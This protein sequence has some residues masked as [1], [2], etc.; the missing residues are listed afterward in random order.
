[1]SNHYR[2]NSVSSQAGLS[3]EQLEDR[4]IPSVSPVPTVDLT[5]RESSGE[6]NGAIFRQADAQPTGTGVINS[7]VRLQALGNKSGAQHGYNTDARPLEFNETKS[8][9]FTRSLRLS[10]VPVVNLGGKAYREFLLDINQRSSQPLLSLDELR[11]YSGTHGDLRGYDCT[12][13]TLAGLAPVYD[14]DGV[15][16]SW[17]LLDYSLNHG[18]GSGDM[19]FYAPDE[20]F[21][22]AAADSFVYLYSKFGGQYAPSAGFEEWAVGKSALTATSGTISGTVFYDRNMDGLQQVDDSENG[23]DQFFV[24]LD[25]DH[26]GVWDE[27]EAYTLT[28]GDGRYAFTGLA[29]GLGDLSTFDVTL[30]FEDPWELTTVSPVSVYLSSGQPDA[31]V[32]FGLIELGGPLT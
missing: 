10:E 31:V 23:L 9:Q 26:D 22:S 19:Y 16:D 27:G 8:P 21:A 17:V 28:D 20:A 5:T 7:F 4:L 3:L 15:G 13:V 29:V 24:F 11:L 12:T 2:L 30:L 25:T 6:I 32:N 18:S 14:M 1:M